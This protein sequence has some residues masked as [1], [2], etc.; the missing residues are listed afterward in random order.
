MSRA[1]LLLRAQQFGAPLV[2]EAQWATRSLSLWSATVA[3]H[4]CHGQHH[5]LHRQSPLQKPWD[6]LLIVH[7]RAWRSNASRQRGHGGGGKRGRDGGG[8]ISLPQIMGKLKKAQ[9]ANEILGIFANH[10]ALLD[11]WA[12][13]NIVHRLGK[14]RREWRRL[15][16]DPRSVA[17][18]KQISEIPKSKFAEQGLSNIVW[19]LATAG[20]E[21]PALFE[22]VA[23]EAVPRLGEFADQGLAMTAWAFA[24]AGVESPALFAAARKLRGPRRVARKRVRKSAGSTGKAARAEART[25]M[26]GDTGEA[27]RDD[28][29]DHFPSEPPFS[30]AFLR[31]AEAWIKRFFG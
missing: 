30:P 28:P 3:H 19:G 5:H 26:A 18:I 27:G 25:E 10:R 29:A 4:G 23:R 9:S 1:L 6:A 31:K 11:P 20:V 13:A 22:A 8:E 7:Q 24:K 14:H 2:A 12:H 16:N 21:A 15:E 17:L